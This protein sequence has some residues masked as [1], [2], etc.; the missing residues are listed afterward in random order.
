MEWFTSMWEV[1]QVFLR[2]SPSRSAVRRVH[3]EVV[4]TWTATHTQ[5]VLRNEQIVIQ[6][7]KRFPSAHPNFDELGIQ[8][9]GSLLRVIPAYGLFTAPLLP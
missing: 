3:D 4:R 7:V 1:G 8:A 5:S 6:G 9:I 2:S